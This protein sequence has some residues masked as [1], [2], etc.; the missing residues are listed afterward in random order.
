MRHTLLAIMGV[1]LCKVSSLLLGC[2]LFD[3]VGRKPL[4]LLSAAGLS[5][6]LVILAVAAA[7]NSNAA[8]AI[9]GLCGLMASFSIGFSPL[10]YV[11]CSELFPSA[12]RARCM[13]LALFTTQ[14]VAGAISSSFV[15]LREFAIPTG[16]WLVYVP[17]SFVGF[18]FVLLA[19][20]ETKGVTLEAMPSLFNGGG[21]A[22]ETWTD[23]VATHR[24][25]A[26]ETWSDGVENNA[27]GPAGDR[28]LGEPFGDAGLV[29]L[30]LQ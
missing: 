4:L 8:L 10:V 12:M 22:S 1:G 13:G 20:P 25:V 24:D 19:V 6:S 27:R 26:L 14:V 5:V 9:G 3:K 23:A 2:L 7:G 11:L 15:S 16:A 17:V 29:T 30:N 21:K 18:F 28:A